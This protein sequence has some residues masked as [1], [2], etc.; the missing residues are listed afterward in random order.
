MSVE[1]D[2]GTLIRMLNP[3]TN[4]GEGSMRFASAGGAATTDLTQV[5]LEVD[6][7]EGH[8][9]FKGQDQRIKKAVRIEYRYPA[10]GAAGEAGVLATEYLLIGYVGAGGGG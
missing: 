3:Y 1:C 4:G 7:Y 6:D 9:T 5:R 2:L 8:W 10:E